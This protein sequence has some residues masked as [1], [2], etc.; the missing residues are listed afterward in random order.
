MNK[1]ERKGQ[2]TS[3]GNIKVKIYYCNIAASGRCLM[4]LLYERGLDAL[5][6]A[7]YS[8]TLG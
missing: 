6:W 7:R 3:L 2:D 1:E 4:G 5:S 8:I